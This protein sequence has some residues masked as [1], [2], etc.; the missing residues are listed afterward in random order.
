MVQG[1]SFSGIQFKVTGVAR[2]DRGLR[3]PID[4]TRMRQLEDLKNL[5]TWKVTRTRN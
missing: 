2:S 3:E 5:R 1:V 4:I